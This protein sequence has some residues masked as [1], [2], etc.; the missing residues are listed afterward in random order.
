ML[1]SLHHDIKSNGRKLTMLVFIILLFLCSWI[2]GPFPTELSDSSDSFLKAAL[3][4]GLSD[5]NTRLPDDATPFIIR[6]SKE[7]LTTIRYAA[8]AMSMAVPTGLI[9]GFLA[10]TAWWP[11]RA[12]GK[13]VRFII[14]PV[15]FFIR[16]LITLMRSVH[17]LIWALLFLAALGQDTITACVALALPFAGTLA[18]V[19]SETIDEQTPHAFRQASASGAG[20]LQ[21]FLSTLIPQ[22]FPEMATYTLYRFE[23]ALRS[24]AVL[25]FIGVETIGLSIKRSFENN[26]YNELW[27]ELYLLL[28]V[29]IIVEILGSK[30]RQRLNSI[31]S[32][33]SQVKLS[34]EPTTRIRQLRK[35]APRWKMTRFLLWSAIILTALSWFPHAVGID[36]QPLTRDNQNIDRIERTSLFLKKLIPEPV[37][38]SGSWAD[39]AGWIHNLWEKNAQEAVI[40]TIAM[41]TAAV[42]LSSICA[43]LLLP[44]ASRNLASVKPLGIYNGKTSVLFQLLWKSIGSITR[45]FFVVSRAIPEYI[46]AY[47]LIGLLG[48][49][50][51]PLVIAL[52][53]HNLGILGRLWGE[54][55]ENQPESAA[56]QIAL[57]GSGRL[58]VYL[59]TYIPATFNRFLMY[60]FYRWE[61][62]IREATVLGMLGFATLGLQIQISRETYRAYDEVIF[63]VLLG[64]ALIFIG[65]LASFFLRRSLNKT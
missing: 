40:N 34:T 45:T 63:Y 36:A 15:Y 42:I 29:I 24:S 23:C 64:S 41:A 18:K 50:A 12:S 44:I 56:Q 4:P 58:K 61:T 51:W 13:L 8:I 26:F 35:A 62:C 16:I 31:P 46:Y 27:T 6:I 59:T 21:A 43:W 1:A 17:E 39:A 60:L 7:L 10:S 55:I 52:A 5:Q 22:S 25:G 14:A 32:S 49:S 37:K 28:A 30:L 20:S 2:L 33:R 57:S 38:E 19:F 9:L 47:L 53:L 3:H 65:D 54:V 48:V 11:P